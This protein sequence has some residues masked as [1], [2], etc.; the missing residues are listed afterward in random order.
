MD[1]L[2]IIGLED[3]ETKSHQLKGFNN[4]PYLQIYYNT[5]TY[6]AWTLENSSYNDYHVYSN[7]AI[8][9]CGNL[10]HPTTAIQ[11]REIIERRINSISPYADLNT[12]A[13]DFLGTLQLQDKQQVVCDYGIIH[14]DCEHIGALIYNTTIQQY[15][16]YNNKFIDFPKI[17]G[18]IANN[19]FCKK[20]GARLG[21]C[22]KK[23]LPE[24]ARNRSIKVTDEEYI[25][26]KQFIA[27]LRA[28]KDS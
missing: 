2:I 19:I 12:R 10:C 20:G 8:I 1:E 14:P 22:R 3:I 5:V 21:S 16:L 6:K 4:P 18:D 7:K 27:D 15:S 25:K 26:V 11:I 9:N 17:D 23:F 24:G 28:G 13:S